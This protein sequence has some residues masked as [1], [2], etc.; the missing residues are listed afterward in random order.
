MKTKLFVI[1][2]GKSVEYEVSLKTAYTVIQSLDFS[3][4][5][6]YP[7]H[8]ARDGRWSCEGVLSSQMS[9][10]QELQ[11]PVDEHKSVAG[12]IGE[13]ISRF[14]TL[15]GQKVALPMLHGSGGEDGTMQGL[16][17]QLDIPY[18][19][20]GVLSSALALDKAVCKSILAD[21]GIP[22]IKHLTFKYK[23]WLE[24][25]HGVQQEI[26][27]D[28]GYPCY[29]KPAS[30]G[31]SVGISR[32][33]DRQA[34]KLAIDEAF[35]YD[36]KIVVE[37]DAAGR[38]IQV[39][40]RGNDHPVASLPGEFIHGQDFFDYE[41][42]YFDPSL[43]MSIPAELTGEMT[44]RIRQT[45]IEAYEALCCSGLARV[46]FFVS[47]QGELYLNEVNT[48]PGFTNYSM[49]PVMW[50]RTDGTPYA[51]LIEKLIDL[52]MERHMER[53]EIEFAR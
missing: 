49:Y 2:G 17:E 44:A 37:R 38:E 19:G 10:L 40:V 26:E 16:L 53:H 45:A 4:Y 24:D 13:I 22:Q 21:A 11:L 39:A 7:I 28:I 6:I 18:I 51:G 48:M 25:A 12:S 43:K 32:C 35:R 41:S 3:R 34:L 8:I 29:V 23:E 42:K 33:E 20:N 31:S 14:F 1:Y 36:R 47:G 15:E 9:Q 30:L 50:E 52:A 46:D 27:Q 5:D